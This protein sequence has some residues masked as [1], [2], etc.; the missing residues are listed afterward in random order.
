MAVRAIKGVSPEW[1][2]PESEKV[3]DDDGELQIP[4][5]AAQFQIRPL[6]QAQLHDVLAEVRPTRMSRQAV[7]FCLRH[8]LVDWRNVVGADDRPMACTVE[9]ALGLPG[10]D[11]HAAH[12]LWSELQQEIAS[13]ILRISWPSEEDRKKS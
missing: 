3:P 2:T 1:F 4:D 11:E 7:T 5:D 6:Q 12:G 9:N 13:E 8:G 10:C